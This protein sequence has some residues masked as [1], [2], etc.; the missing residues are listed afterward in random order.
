MRVVFVN[1]YFHPDHSATSQM[2]SDLAFHLA[3]R[4]WQVAAI[5]SRQLY[6][7]PESRLPRR[8]NVRGVEIIRTSATTF[9]RA[10]LFGR[11]VDYLTFAFNALLLIRKQKNSLIVA[12]TDPPLTSVVAAMS[13]RPFVNWIQDLFPDV[14]E[15]LGVRAPRWLHRL[16]DWSLRRA[17][18]NVVIGEQMSARVPNAIVQHHWADAE[19][20][21]VDVPHDNFVVGYSG[22][23]GRAHDVT[24]MIGAMRLLRDD[25]NVVFSIRGGGAKLDEIRKE[26]LPNVRF[27]PYAAR[28]RL[29][30]SLSSADAHLVTLNPS[31]EGL[32]VPSKFYGV[33]AVARPLL[34][35]GSPGGELAQLVAEHGLG[36]VIEP[37][38]SVT[39][40]NAIR[41]LSADAGK[42]TEMGRRAR[43]L[44]V[45]RFA[46]GIALAEWEKILSMLI[47]G[48]A[49]EGS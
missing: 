18:R 24:T 20:H 9:G 7:E 25:A 33:I 29:S 32:I 11:G 12:M 13:G 37:G 6:D 48:L 31:L 26:N 8:E 22:N 46:P 36:Y 38:E 41:E 15:A 44:Y 35:I 39:L 40:A 34:Y 49:G 3:S 21:P 30:E 45:S 2:V 43:S 17:Q 10:S 28:A 5:T 19:L 27:E 47:N 23:L 42:R 4:G 14:A 16:R 1:R